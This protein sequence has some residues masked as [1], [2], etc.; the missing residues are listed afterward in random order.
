[1]SNDPLRTPP[2]LPPPPHHLPPPQIVIQQ[3]SERG[4]FRKW[5]NRTL[6]ALLVVSVIINFVVIATYSEYLSNT[7]PPY[8]RFRAGEVGSSDKIAVIQV[9]GTI[10]PPFTDNTLKAIKR[11]REDKAVK[12]V[13]LAVD[14][15]GGLVA[16]SHMIYHDLKRLSGE[17]PVF[18]QMKRMAAS[19]GYYIAMGAGEKGTIYVE[20]T[21]WTG[22]IGVIIP[23]YDL[24][25]LSTD[26]GVKS[27]PLTTGPFKDAL[28]PFREMSAEETEIWKTIMQEAFNR[29]LTVIDENRPNLDR[30]QIE[31]LATGQVYTA[32]QAIAN[33][34]ADKVGYEEDAIAALEQQL[35][36]KKCR[37]V[38]YESPKGLMEVLL[39]SAEQSSPNAQMRELLETTVP[40]AMYFCSWAPGMLT[41]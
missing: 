21:T 32:D 39:G 9:S 40:R 35:G 22:S 4:L 36:L 25:K 23:R 17:K 16:D 24:S 1:M 28:S 38:T 5:L 31:K 12:G 6:L 18:V 33:G 8:E 14:S 27:D 13:L 20:P 30:P 29:F 37:V 26:I 10:S 11:A 7:T 2:P 34:L 15:P 3:P 41:Q 19:G